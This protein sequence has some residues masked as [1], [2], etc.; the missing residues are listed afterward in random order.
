MARSSR[1]RKEQTLPGHLHRRPNTYALA[2]SANGAALLALA[3]P[4]DAE[5]VYTPTNGLVSRNGSF[6]LDLNNDGIVDFTVVE[7][8]KRT[9]LR[10]TQLLSVIPAQGN[11]VMC[12]WVPI[13]AGQTTGNENDA[14]AR[15]E[16]APRIH[17]ASRRLHP[18]SCVRPL[19]DPWSPHSASTASPS[20]A[21]R[22]GTN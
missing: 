5:I 9:S 16:P 14:T 4:S 13:R 2:A 1:S 17:P 11:Q 22:K 7:L 18:P 12:S 19:C 15:P 8:A 3:P 21:R 10:S 6:N 20:G